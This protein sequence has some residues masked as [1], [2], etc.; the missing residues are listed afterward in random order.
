MGEDESDRVRRELAATIESLSRICPRCMASTDQAS[1]D[2][3]HA[4]RPCPAKAGLGIGILVDDGV[5]R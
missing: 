2:A 4:G 5:P 1:W 3:L